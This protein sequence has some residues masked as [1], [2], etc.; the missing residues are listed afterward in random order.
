MS[1]F[2]FYHPI[3]VRYGDL[4]PQGHLNNAKYLTYFEQARI[5][6]VRYLGLFIEGQSFLD[7]G[8]IVADIHIAYRQPINWD[9]PVKVGVRTARLGTKSMTVE[10]AVV[11]AQSD[12]V[13]A[14]GEVILVAFD[15]RAG[16]S[17]SIP[18]EWREKILAF[19]GLSGG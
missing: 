18:N 16:K 4:D 2:R 5:Q 8:V 11:H 12:A 3:E 10:Q 19:E 17:I 14:E 6:Y 7:I 9:T 15:Y 13:L 1:I